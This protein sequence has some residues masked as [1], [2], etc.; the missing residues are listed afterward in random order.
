MTSTGKKNFAPEGKRVSKLKMVEMLME[1][2]NKVPP[3]KSTP[4]QLLNPKVFYRLLPAPDGEEKGDSVTKNKYVFDVGVLET[5]EL[6][7]PEDS[8]AFFELEEKKNANKHVLRKI[9]LPLWHHQHQQNVV[10]LVSINAALHTKERIDLRFVPLGEFAAKENNRNVLCQLISRNLNNIA[11]P[12]VIAEATYQECLE[13]K[14][15]EDGVELFSTALA[16]K[17]APRTK[18]KT[19]KKK[20]KTKK[21]K[22]NKINRIGFSSPIGWSSPSTRKKKKHMEHIAKKRK[23]CVASASIFI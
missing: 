6:E 15:W 21:K 9:S 16:G 10:G 12:Y 1:K 4:Q 17:V 20:K 14:Y 3:V 18:K 8:G 7:A 2:L 23:T 13:L 5:L 19:N 11:S 22:T